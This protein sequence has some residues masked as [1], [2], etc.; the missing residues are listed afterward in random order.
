MTK[1]D[2]VR[3]QMHQ[4]QVDRMKSREK[5]IV[6]CE[7]YRKV[8]E[9]R[10]AEA[11]AAAADIQEK[12]PAALIEENERLSKKLRYA[13]SVYRNYY[14]LVGVEPVS[15]WR[16]FLGR[17]S[18]RYVTPT[19]GTCNR[20]QQT[21]TAADEVRW[22]GEVLAHHDCN[23]GLRPSRA[24]RKELRELPTTSSE[25]ALS[26]EATLA[27]EGKTDEALRKELGELRRTS[28][29]MQAQSLKDLIRAHQTQSP[30]SERLLS[31]YLS[32][33]L[34]ATQARAGQRIL[35]GLQPVD[36]VRWLLRRQPRRYRAPIATTCERCKQ[37]IDGQKI[38][39]NGQAL[40]HLECTQRN[41]TKGS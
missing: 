4:A 26:P 27:A 12:A 8:I 6:E 15:E 17:R 18:E 25:P 35:V 36:R 20:C 33:E 30:E 7:H 16:W 28:S 23:K 2:E 38:E 32:N 3:E 24:L 40:V 13:E 11:I 34:R 10:K 29:E 41:R 19:R 1:Y 5:L 37:R 22:Q 39:L 9:E 21:L 14:T 31:E